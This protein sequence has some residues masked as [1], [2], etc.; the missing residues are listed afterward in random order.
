MMSQLAMTDINMP[1]ID[2]AVDVV[3]YY[4]RDVITNE[5]EFITAEMPPLKPRKHDI[6]RCASFYILIITQAIRR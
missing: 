2:E 5:I 1:R 3:N 4:L 6:R